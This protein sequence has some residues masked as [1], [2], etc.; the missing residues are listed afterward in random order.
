MRNT[1]NGRPERGL[2]WF[3]LAVL[4]TV[5]FLGLTGCMEKES[6]PAEGMYSVYYKNINHTGINYYA[7]RAEGDSREELVQDLWRQ[8]CLKPEEADRES[9]VPAEVMLLTFSLDGNNISLYF[10]SALAEMDTVAQLLFRA[11]VVKTFTGIEGIETVTFFADE[12]PLTDQNYTP[13]GAQSS[14][15]YVDIISNGL[16][17]TRKTT[18]VLYYTDESGEKLLRYTKDI[19]YQSS[20]SLERDVINRLIQ[21]PDEE[22]YYATLPSGLKLISINV[23]DGTC[24]VN[25]D[26]VFLTDSLPIS[27]YT[28]V[29]SIVNS[30]SELAEVKRV[31]IMVNGDSNVTFKENISLASPLERNLNLTE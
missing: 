22:G 2:C 29:Y 26:S 28:I 7:Y 1:R 18:L 16:S 10:N 24:Y 19:V 12:K 8:L 13:L 17:S 23:K 5:C 30:L 27:G 25:F 31:Q 21:G 20:Y 4:W 9:V 14:S 15:D 11:A 6:S 3:V